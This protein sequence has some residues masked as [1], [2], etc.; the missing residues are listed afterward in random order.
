MIEGI[1]G[2]LRMFFQILSKN[3][4]KVKGFFDFILQA[5]DLLI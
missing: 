4:A 3:Y 5:I 2:H 1:I